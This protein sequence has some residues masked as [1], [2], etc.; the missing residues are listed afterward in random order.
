MGVLRFSF[1]WFR[2][3]SYIDTY[4][5]THTQTQ[6]L[7]HRGPEFSPRCSPPYVATQG[8]VSRRRAL[9]HGPLPNFVRNPTYTSFRTTSSKEHRFTW[10]KMIFSL[11]FCSFLVVCL[12]LL[13]TNYKYFRLRISRTEFSGAI[14]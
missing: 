11:G 10:I 7:T 12:H 13:H 8:T 4:T 9:D 2:F 5:H 6:T 14:E 1:N 3:W